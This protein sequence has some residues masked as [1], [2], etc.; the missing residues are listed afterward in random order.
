MT[1]GERL[2]VRAVPRRTGLCVVRLNEEVR[3]GCA[4]LGIRA[5]WAAGR[6]DHK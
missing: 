2:S 4:I 3:L 1:L 5:E 6:V